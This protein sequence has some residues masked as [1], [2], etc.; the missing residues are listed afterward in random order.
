M[1]K[2]ARIENGIVVE[3]LEAEFL[4]QFHPSLVWVDC[5]DVVT[6]GYLYDGNAFTSPEENITVDEVKSAKTALLKAHR[7]EKYDLGHT[8]NG[9]VFQI[10]AEAQ[11]NMIAIMTQFTLG[12]SNPHGG[13]WRD[14]DNVA[15]AMNDAEVQ[16][17]IQASFSYIMAIKN[18]FWYHDAQIKALNA[19]SDIEDYDFTTGWP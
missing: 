18:Q 9:D 3:T 10:D 14:V 4:P 5:P 11:T 12:N 15:V 17:F 16:A 7:N 19:K 8:Y 1:A 2:F 13:V 6:E